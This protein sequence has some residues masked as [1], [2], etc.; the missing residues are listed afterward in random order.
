M[1]GPSPSS[2]DGGK[3]DR[4][5]QPPKCPE[6]GSTKVWR[7]GTRRVESGRVQRY[8][9]R[10]CGFR[11]TDPTQRLKANKRIIDSAEYASPGKGWTSGSKNSAKAVGALRREEESR[12]AGLREAATNLKSLLFNFAWYLKKNGYAPSTIE[13]RVKLLRQLAQRGADLYDPESVKDVI[14]KQDSWSNARK[15]L[16]VQ[17]YTSFLMMTGGSWRPPAYERIESLPFIPYEREIDALIAGCSKPIS[18]FLRLLKE[19]GMRPGEAFNLRWEDIDPERKTITIKP[20]KKSNPRIYNVSEKLIGTLLHL[21][22]MNKDKKSNLFGYGSLNYLRRTFERQR[23]RIAHKLNNPR[24]RRITF[25]TLRHWKATTLYHQT[26]DILYV[27]RF[28]GHK[29]IKNTLVYVQLEEAL[30]HSE[31]EEYVC[32]A[33]KTVKEAMEL[34]EKG[35]EYVCEVEGVSLFRKRK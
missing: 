5:S 23:N 10:E 12:K 15:E 32:K 21:K 13:T 1:R 26:K 9:C 2:V 35:F 3:A 34:V 17:A 29:N 30:F 33:V 7:D 14:A 20:E 6:C 27:M 31:K 25:K 28:L 24:L 8:L 4:T 19:T 22:N 11:F 16:A 18:A